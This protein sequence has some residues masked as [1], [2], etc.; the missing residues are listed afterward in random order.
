MNLQKFK[1]RINCICNESVNFEVIDEIECDWGSHVV[2]Q[3]PK[4]QELFSIDN[5]CPAFH[6][7]LDLEKNNFNLFSDKEKF[8][9]ALNPHPN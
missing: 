6:D 9:Y 7:V 1:D 8:D 2:I 3:C 5:S 4:C